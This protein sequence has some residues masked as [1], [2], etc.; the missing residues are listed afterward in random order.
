[1][2]ISD[3]SSD[4]CSS[5]LARRK[6]AKVKARIIDMV[7]AELGPDYDVGTHFT[8]R[9]NPWDQR[10]CLVPDADLFVAIR[11]GR[12]SVVNDT[13]DTFTETGIKLDAG[14]DIAGDNVVNATGLQVQFRR[15]AIEGGSCRDREF[16]G[17]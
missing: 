17:K 3:W 2:R 9:Y 6:P 13:N 11:E 10:L 1:M 12:A 15:E 14:P 5:D 7:Q 8:P 4:V 16:Q